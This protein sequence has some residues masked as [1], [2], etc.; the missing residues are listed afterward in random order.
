MGQPYNVGLS[1]AN[2][3]KNELCD[4]IGK[5]VPG[6]SPLVSDINKDPDQRNYIVSNSR[7]ERT[8]YRPIFSLD[9]GIVEL[10]KVY[11]IIRLNQY[12]NI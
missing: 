8:G 3:S 5:Y 10:I 2:L 12:S 1:D 7:I 9:Q 6:F 4:V 11:Q